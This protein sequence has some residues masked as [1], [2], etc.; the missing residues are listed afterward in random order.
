MKLNTGTIRWADG[1]TS[2]VVIKEVVTYSW[3]PADYWIDYEPGESH[4]PLVHPDWGTKEGIK[5]PILLP[6]ELFFRSFTRDR[7][8]NSFEYKLDEYIKANFR[9]SEWFEADTTFKSLV[10][11]AGED[12]VV[13]N[14]FEK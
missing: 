3:L 13:K 11:L 2:R 14:Y 5:A 4:R 9:E 10:R 12:Y 1:T 6:E 8:P 7:D